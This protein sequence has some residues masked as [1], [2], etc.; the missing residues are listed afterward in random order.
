MWC[1]LIRQE[2]A[3]AGR[4]GGQ[5][6]F[7]ARHS[8]G[9]VGAR[10]RGK[11]GRRDTGT[12]RQTQGIWE[13]RAA[14]ARERSVE[15]GRA[16]LVCC[17]AE[18]NWEQ[19]LL[20]W[21]CHT[22]R[23]TGGST[24]GQFWQLFPRGVRSEIF[25]REILRLRKIFTKIR[26]TRIKNRRGNSH[27]SQSS[28]TLFLRLSCCSLQ[29]A[30]CVYR[31]LNTRLDYCR[32]DCGDLVVGVGGACLGAGGYFCG[33]C[34]GRAEW[35]HKTNLRRKARPAKESPVLRVRGWLCASVF[36]NAVCVCRAEGAGAVEKNI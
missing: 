29:N 21:Y 20:L 6:P 13:T 35:T 34:T 27:K 24:S 3:A 17:V 36:K 9:E 12:P 22:A 25:E 18:T 19:I 15:S 10:A 5:V 8:S 32:C 33:G 26:P 28:K 16:F 14:I 4:F 7:S 31:W 23:K 1:H 2:A 11:R 30:K